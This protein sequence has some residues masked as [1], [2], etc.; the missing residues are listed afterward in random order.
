MHCAAEPNWERK[1]LRIAV[2]ALLAVASVSGESP[3]AHLAGGVGTISCLMFDALANKDPSWG[4]SRSRD[5]F[6]TWA[7]GFMMGSNL[8]RL[9]EGRTTAQLDSMSF[10]EQWSRLRSYCAA[11]P[12]QS[13]AAGVLAL[14]RS[15]STQP[16]QD[17][18]SH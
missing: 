4:P 18:G 11:H 17:G 2:A 14:Y 15:L 7:L 6:M 1:I 10:D 9:G 13:F 5:T 3:S 16:N 8:E 12:D